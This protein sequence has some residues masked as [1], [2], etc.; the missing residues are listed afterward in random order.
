[1]SHKSDRKKTGGSRLVNN[2]KA[3]LAVIGGSQAYDL[4]LSGCIKGKR[5]GEINTPYGR[6]QPVYF[7]RDANAEML[8]LS[9]HG[10]KGYGVTAPFVNY[11][12]NIY[13]L[14][15]LGAKQIVSWSGPG[16]MNENYKIGEYVLIDD[17]ID[18]T[19]GRESTFY[20]HLGIGFIRQFPVFCPT[21][22]ESILHTLKFLGIGITGKGVYVCTQGPR[23]E[24]PA[25]IRKYKLYGGDLV[26]MT[27]V[28]EVFLAKELEMCYASICY[29]TNYAE[30]IAS[31]PFKAGELFEGL[32]TDS[33]REAV[34]S[35]VALFPQIIKKI[36]EN[37]S[38][39]KMTC[40][41]Q[42]LMER[43]KR[44][45]DIGPDWHSWVAMP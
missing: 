15:E 29:V 5:L 26:G 34:R 39:Q 6:S 30:G 23:L 9:R 44:R 19:H 3:S 35:A 24:T 38:Q 37:S 1:M 42:S 27:L 28:P 45:G 12:A 7:I 8:F 25:E 14:K 22:R 10:E 16:A 4:L 43:Y 33:D 36:A 40:Q 13:A 18:E 31:R 11:R 41:C 20:K 17:I 21:L 2:T 32:A